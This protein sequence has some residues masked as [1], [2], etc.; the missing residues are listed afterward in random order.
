M[1]DLGESLANFKLNLNML[2]SPLEAPPEDEFSET[3][4]EQIKS[5]PARARILV[6]NILYRTIKNCVFCSIE[7]EIVC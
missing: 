4:G 5:S 3:T 1:E 7:N 6:R 2:K